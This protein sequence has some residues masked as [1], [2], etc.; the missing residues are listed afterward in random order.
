MTSYELSKAWFD[1]AFENPE[2]INPNHSAIFFFAVEHCNRLGWKEK[3]GFPTQMAMDAV[4]IKKHQ[5]YIKYF[6]ELVD[7]GFFKLVQ[8]SSNQYSANIIS[9]INALPK[10]GKALG[11]AIT[12]HAA[13]QTEPMGQSTGQSNSSIIKLD[14]YKPDN[15]I[16]YIKIGNEIF[17]KKGSEIFLDEYKSTLDSWLMGKMRGFDKDELLERFDLEYPNYEFEDRNHFSNSLKFVFEKIQKEK[18]SAK[19]EKDGKQQTSKFQQNVT[20]ANEV[21]AILD[22]NKQPPSG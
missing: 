22:R 16:T 14:N 9:L 21:L 11:K 17:Y 20:A 15:Q 12:T 19:K 3:F 5:T 4:G 18:N 7:W 1:F 2:K 10:K 6:N 13:K 8:K